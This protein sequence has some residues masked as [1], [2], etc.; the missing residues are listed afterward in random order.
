M[1]TS[2]NPTDAVAG[3]RLVAEI[4]VA[5]AVPLEFIVVR[6]SQDAEGRTDVVPVT[7]GGGT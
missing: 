6:I 4:G 5:P 1:T 3:G 2:L 7:P